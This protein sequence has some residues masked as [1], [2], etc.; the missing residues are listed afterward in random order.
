M[1]DFVDNKL[2]NIEYLPFHET[3]YDNLITK[4][5]VNYIPKKKIIKKK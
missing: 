3:D 2:I 5:N 4:P 1:I